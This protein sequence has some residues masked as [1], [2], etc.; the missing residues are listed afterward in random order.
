MRWNGEIKLIL[1]YYLQITSYFEEVYR[2]DDCFL[3]VKL[4]LDRIRV[5]GL[6]LNAESIRYS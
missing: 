6:E 2:E 4:D 3:L 1:H 5:L